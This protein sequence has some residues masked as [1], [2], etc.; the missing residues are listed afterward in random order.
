M[1]PKVI[2]ALMALVPMIA[3]IRYIPLWTKAKDKRFWILFQGMVT[4]A[5]FFVSTGFFP[6]IAEK[7]WW[8]PLAL[9][10]LPSLV[11]SVQVRA[12]MKTLS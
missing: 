10:L 6:V 2:R 4:L 7:M 12:K 1:F 9:L 5:F 3:L 11:V 8:I